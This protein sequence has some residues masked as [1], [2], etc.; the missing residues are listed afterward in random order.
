MR[1]GGPGRS[2][3]YRA[4]GLAKQDLGLV[5]V[6]VGVGVLDG[7]VVGGGVGGCVGGGVTVGNGVSVGGGDSSGGCIG[8]FVLI[9]II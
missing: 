2:V 3:C 7:V 8:V 1:T 5:V 9:I 4:H 6:V